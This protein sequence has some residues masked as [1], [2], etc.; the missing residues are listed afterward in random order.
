[1]SKNQ[2]INAWTVIIVCE[3]LYKKLGKLLQVLMTER[4]TECD[5]VICTPHEFKA[6]THTSINKVIYLENSA[7]FRDVKMATPITIEKKAIDLGF[8][9]GWRG[10][11]AVIYIDPTRVGMENREDVVYY[12][13]NNTNVDNQY[14]ENIAVR[15]DI[16]KELNDFDKF[17][18]PFQEMFNNV[19]NGPI[20]PISISN[21]AHDMRFA[22][23]YK[24]VNDDEHGMTVFLEW[25]GSE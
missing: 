2:E 22:L 16:K 4:D 9:Y 12:I 11:N 15:M 5:V 23:V 24:F 10:N 14:Y 18:L 7:P 6:L 19:E 25:N 13:K 8:N 3:N 21:F 17:L 20:D 1:M